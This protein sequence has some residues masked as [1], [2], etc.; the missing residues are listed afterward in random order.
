MSMH[1]YL[2]AGFKLFDPKEFTRSWMEDH[3][4]DGAT[5]LWEIS[6]RLRGT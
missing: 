3:L 1:L 6:L 4:V 2:I 5:S